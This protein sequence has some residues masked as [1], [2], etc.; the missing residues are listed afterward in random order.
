LSGERWTRGRARRSKPVRTAKSCGPD[1]PTLGSSLPMT[2]GRRRWLKKPGHRGEHVISRKAIAQGRPGCLGRVCGTAACVSCCG[3]AMGA[4][5]ARSSL[6]PLFW[7]SISVQNSGRSCRGK[8][9]SHPLRCHAPRMRGIQ[10]AAA[11]RL[12]HWRLWNTGSPGQAG[13]RH[14]MIG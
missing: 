11:R 2:T 14:R 1:L 12:K 10:Y 3:R 7:G 6:C 8:V 13:R 5:S 4:A 9:E